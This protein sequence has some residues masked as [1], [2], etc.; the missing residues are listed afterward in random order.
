MSWRFTDLHLPCS[1]SRPAREK[2]K[3]LVRQRE[4]V[5]DKGAELWWR[6]SDSHSGQT[7]AKIPERSEI[8]DRQHPES[9]ILQDPGSYIFIFSRDVRDLGS[10]QDNIAV[11]Y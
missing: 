6:C 7:C 10:C 4:S 9:G 2:R 3:S 1:V 11:G 5:T 8:L